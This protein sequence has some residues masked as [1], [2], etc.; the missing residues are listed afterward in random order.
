ME[1]GGNPRIARLE[2]FM[3]RIGVDALL[4]AHSPNMRYFTGFTGGEGILLVL[5]PEQILF[6]DA[7]YTLRARAECSGV[8][9]REAVRP[10]EA[11]A[12][13][14]KGKGILRVGLETAHLTVDRFRQVRRLLG[15]LR[16]KSLKD[17]LDTLRMVKDAGEIDKIQRAI[18]IH[19]GALYETLAWLTP[20]MTE[21]DWA[22][23]FE[24]RARRHGAAALAFETIVAS[25]PRSAIPHATA[26]P[27]VLADDGPI[28]FD[29][30]VVYE[31]YCSD[32][33]ATFFPRPPSG[34]F[35]EIYR[36][37]QEA[38]DR[39]IAAVRPGLPAAAIDAAARDFI[40]EA[41][42]GEAFTHG[43]GHGVGLEIHERPTIGPR[44]TTR[45]EPGMVFTVEPGI[46]LNGRGGVRI[47]DM[48]CV[49]DEGCRVLT[50][51]PKSLTVIFE[52]S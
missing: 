11:A 19:T 42:Y 40:R 14:L 33:T 43:T 44:D 28:V 48:V 20:D 50:K 16:V 24:Y 17:R 36:I 34:E 52:N 39:A 12:E 22:V 13:V 30:G 18:D 21:R 29:H 7:R 35:R 49:T 1:T 31:G 5:P 38:H 2:A 37:V 4:V 3:E 9:V 47:E 45:L 26:D 25:G 15:N 10:V 41:G 6:V 27:V 23:E 46:Y 32:E 8:T 51:C